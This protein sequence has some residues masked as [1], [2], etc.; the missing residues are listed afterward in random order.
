M[1]SSDRRE[2]AP[3]LSGPFRKLM[4]AMGFSFQS[5]CG[6]TANGYR[7]FPRKSILVLYILTMHQAHDRHI[8][9]SEVWMGDLS[10][11]ILRP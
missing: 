1:Q 7:L 2:G 8:R 3:G 9:S 5:H 6:R 11:F 4:Q 10:A